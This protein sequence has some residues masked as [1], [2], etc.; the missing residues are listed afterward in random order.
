MASFVTN[1]NEYSGYFQKYTKF[2]LSA[3]FIRQGGEYEMEI[4]SAYFSL[5]SQPK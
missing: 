1:K 2:K 3:N 5:M 4:I